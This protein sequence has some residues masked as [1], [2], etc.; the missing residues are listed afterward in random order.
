MENLGPPG[1]GVSV[2][3]GHAL[4][5]ALDELEAAR[6]A[7]EEPKEGIDYF[8]EEAELVRHFEAIGLASLEYVK[9]NFS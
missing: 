9:S 8:E 3:Q 6:S 7:D 5:T 4:Q 1:I 2:W